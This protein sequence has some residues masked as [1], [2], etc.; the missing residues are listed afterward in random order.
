MISVL[1]SAVWVYIVCKKIEADT[2]Y[3]RRCTGKLLKDALIN[4]ESENDD[5]KLMMQ[6]RYYVRL[7]DPNA[8]VNHV[9]QEVLSSLLSS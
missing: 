9:L 7:P 4:F 2:E 1:L 6:L 5:S 8:H 3:M